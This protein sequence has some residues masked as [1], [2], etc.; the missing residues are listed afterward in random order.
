MASPLKRKAEKAATSPTTKKQKVV[1]PEYHST[2]QR[3]D[4]AGETVWPA[5]KEQIER[6]RDIIK[7]WYVCI[8]KFYPAIN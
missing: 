8:L 1:V 6:A 5:R 4:E 7:E 3:R 2:P